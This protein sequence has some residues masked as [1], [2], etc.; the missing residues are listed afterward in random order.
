MDHI[1][2]DVM[3]YVFW[4]L[5]ISDQRTLIRTCKNIHK[6]A[7]L[8]PIIE[9]LYQKKI[10]NKF[11]SK[12]PFIAF[13]NP[14]YKHTLELIHDTYSIPD[15]YMIN[16]N[17]IL[18]QYTNIWYILGQQGQYDVIMQMIDSKI[19]PLKNYNPNTTYAMMGF[20]NSGHWKLIKKM[21]AHNFV[22]TEDVAISAVKGNQMKIFEKIYKKNIVITQHSFDAC[23]KY[24]CIDIYDFI[25]S[26]IGDEYISQYTLYATACAG[27]LDIIKKIKKF[28][29]FVSCQT[30]EGAALCGHLDILKWNYAQNCPMESIAFAYE[31]GHIHILE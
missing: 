26:K 9:L 25:V 7:R 10:N 14:L 30:S 23:A 31:G 28:G 18:H 1:N 8:I 29:D 15:K 27:N 3:E 5:P 20:A 19:C 4:M 11:F 21:L 17:R 12:N 2:L 13:Y 24:N 6:L 22:L 16:E